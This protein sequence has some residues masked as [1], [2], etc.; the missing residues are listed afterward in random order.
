MS[1]NAIISDAEP[2]D[3]PSLPPDPGTLRGLIEIPAIRNYL[4]AGLTALAM[5]FLI[6]LSQNSDIGGLMLV[7]LGTAG[8]IFRWPAV[9]SFFLIVLFW[10]LVFPF[11]L[12][13]GYENPRELSHGHFRIA[14]VLLAFSVVVYLAS[15][16]RI[17]GLSA[18]A[19][20][21]EARQPRKKP[22]P[23]RRPIDLIRIGELPRLLAITAGIV[24]VSQIVWLIVT[25]LDID[26]NAAFPIVAADNTLRGRSAPL[27]G[28]TRMLLLLGAGFFGTLLARLVFGYWQLRV[29]NPTEAGMMLQDAG[30]D[31]TRRELTR[32]EKW[33]IWSKDRAAN[34]IEREARRG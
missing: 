13:P 1:A 34:T 31:E 24:I 19:M 20:P 11:G 16:Y 4:F 25:S 2:L 8:M 27:R 17:Y 14:D 22:K 9:P 5:I 30:W 10:F 3:E 18:Q 23:V 12:W 33:R 6:M 32:V 26:V 15:H 21:L 29:M 28:G 7:I